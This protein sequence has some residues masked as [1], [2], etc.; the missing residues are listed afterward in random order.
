MGRRKEGA[1]LRSHVR[2]RARGS[3]NVYVIDDRKYVIVSGQ[4]RR[5][6]R[7]ISL[8]SKIAFIRNKKREKQVLRLYLNTRSGKSV[9]ATNFSFLLSIIAKNMQI[10]T[11][12]LKRKLYIFI[13]GFLGRLTAFFNFQE[14]R[15]E[16]K[17]RK[18]LMELTQ[19]PRNYARTGQETN[20]SG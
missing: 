6:R 10:P 15:S 12:T 8:L 17:T 4:S 2:D 7:G 13:K 20:T 19:M 5:T 3:R 1:M 9:K 16:H 11:F 18:G 14:R